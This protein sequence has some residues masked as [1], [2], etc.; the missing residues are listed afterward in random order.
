[1]WERKY[2]SLFSFV[3]ASLVWL[4]ENKKKICWRAQSKGVWLH[5]ARLHAS[6][7]QKSRCT[8]PMIHGYSRSDKKLI[9]YNKHSSNGL[10]PFA[11]VWWVENQT[12][13]W[14]PQAFMPILG[15]GG[16]FLEEV[17]SI[18]PQPKGKVEKCNRLTTHMPL[19]PQAQD[20]IQYPILSTHRHIHGPLPPWQTLD[21]GRDPIPSRHLSNLGCWD[22]CLNL[23]K[24][25]HV[26]R[27]T[28]MATLELGSWDNCLN[29]MKFFVDM[30][31]TNFHTMGFK[32]KNTQQG[33]EASSLVKSIA[34]CSKFKPDHS[35][36]LKKIQRRK[37]KEMFPWSFP[38]ERRKERKKEL[39]YP[40]K[41]GT[42]L[43]KQNLLY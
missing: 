29:L 12:I 24:I 9:R 38:K 28:W 5:F 32:K 37:N 26:T 3:V 2:G 41:G 39:T 40:Q 14:G 22:E 16:T 11:H 7:T 19:A 10:Q 31:V 13:Q 27:L 15:Y 4:Q 25:C 35:F 33:C 43:K 21:L 42:K 8:Q 23:M 1:M 18:A 30:K 17:G 20:T 36:F 34:I 6:H